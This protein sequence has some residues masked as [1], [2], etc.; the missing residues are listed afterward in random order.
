ML[1]LSKDDLQNLLTMEQAI[2][3]MKEAYITFSKREAD[4]PP[5]THIEIPEGKGFAL[6][7]PGY[8]PSVKSFGVKVVSL[9]PNNTAKD[10]PATIGVIIL[11]DPQSGFPEVLLDGTFLT[12]LRTGAGT[13]IATAKLAR[14]DSK[15][16]GLIGTGSQAY[17]QLEGVVAVRPI[18]TIL[19][20][21]RTAEKGKRFVKEVRKTLKRKDLEIRFVE[22]A[23]EAAQA[24]II[25]TSTS[26]NTPVLKGE[27]IREGTH[28]N[29][30]GA[31][32]PQMQEI[33][34]EVVRKSDLITVDSKEGTKKVGDLA[35]P[36]RKNVI[37]EDDIVEIGEILC[38]ED[39]GR[40]TDSDITLFKSV[41][42]AVQDIYLG[43]LAYELSEKNG[44]G[45]KISLF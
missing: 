19:I 32:S 21:N 30:I 1:Y 9:F 4:I 39:R 18:K 42:I 33:D 40:K 16:L 41:G 35:I 23:E 11:F 10:L 43:K 26:A 27:W 37:K 38:N 28:I 12:S 8:V 5:R 17:H 36:L 20:Y 14:E 31:F 45:R 7:M 15:T 24:D 25:I 44:I 29:A 13:G 22:S 3:C 6:F 2:E 34:E